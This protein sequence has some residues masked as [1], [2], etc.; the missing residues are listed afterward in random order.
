MAAD[1]KVAAMCEDRLELTYEE[2]ITNFSEVCPALFSF[3]SLTPLP[4]RTVTKWSS[5]FSKANR[6]PLHRMVSNWNVVCREAPS[7]IQMWLNPEDI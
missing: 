5:A 3:L 6:T 1:M 2:L 4:R 7:D